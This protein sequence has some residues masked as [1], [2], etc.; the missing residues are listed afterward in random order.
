MDN[1][2]AEE[3]FRKYMNLIRKYAW[4]F[5]KRCR[6]QTVDFEELLSNGYLIF[7][8]VLENYD[9]TKGAFSTYLYAN[10]L[11]MI[12]LWY[13][14]NKD[15]I[16]FKY[17]DD[18]LLRCRSTSFEEFSRTLEFYDAVATELSADAQVVLQYILQSPEKKHSENSLLDYFHKQLKWPVKRVLL[19]LSELRRWW[20]YAWT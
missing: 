20:Q 5:V 8:R 9:E 4:K 13:R 17:D 19:T 11:G 6:L 2:Y 7:L 12:E 1:V 18:L 3:M 15:V 14:E 16:H 10:L